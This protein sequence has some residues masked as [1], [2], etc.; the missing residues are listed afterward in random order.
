MKKC[1]HGVD[2]KEAICGN[3]ESTKRRKQSLK[4]RKAIAPLINFL[5]PF[6]GLP[7]W[8]GC[9]SC[10]LPDFIVPHH[11]VW[12]NE[13]SG[14]SII[15]EA[16]WQD[17]SEKEKLRLY[18]LAWEELWQQYRTWGEIEKAI[19]YPFHWRNPNGPFLKITDVE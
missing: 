10:G 16:C 14:S 3:C 1:R 19:V 4:L 6:F 5:V 9:R 15:C 7:M 18:R 8:A 13:G 17:I 11:T 2:P 12:Y